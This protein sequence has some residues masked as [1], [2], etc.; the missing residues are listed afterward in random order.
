M[1]AARRASSCGSSSRSRITTAATSRSIP[2]PPG[3][4]DF[5]LLY[6][7]SADGGSGGDPLKL[8]QNPGSAFGKLLRIDPLG[9]NSANGKYGFPA[10]NPFATDEDPATLGE[11]FASGVRNPQRFAWDPKNGTLFVSDIGQNTVEEISR[12]RRGQPRLERWEGSFRFISRDEVS[13]ENPRG[14][15]RSRT[16]S[17]S[18]ARSIL[19]SSRRSP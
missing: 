13:L 19:C 11:I 1:M 3:S 9:R 17:S 15:A 6:V 16:R 8:S 5:G 2:A 14:D 7:G 12:L 10:S 4:A 18:T